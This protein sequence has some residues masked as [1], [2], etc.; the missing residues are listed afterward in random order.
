MLRLICL[1]WGI[2][3][4][5]GT[6][7]QQAVLPI[8]QNFKYPIEGRLAIDVSQGVPGSLWMVYSDRDHNPIYTS[9]KGEIRNGSLAFLEAGYVVDV[10]GEYMHLYTDPEISVRGGL[11]AKAKEIGWVH[12]D[13]VL[14]WTH[15]LMHPNKVARKSM[16]LNQVSSNGASSVT[17]LKAQVL[18]FA[19]NPQRSVVSD[20][21]S[22]LFEIFYV[23]KEE[24]N[25]LLLGQGYS[26]AGTEKVKQTILG[27]VP[28]SR[29]VPWDYRIAT[30]PN[31]YHE[32]A[33]ER[34]KKGKSAQVF[35][36][37]EDAQKYKRNESAAAYWK[38]DTYGNRPSGYWRRFP[39]LGKTDDIW[40]VGLM[41]SVKTSTGLAVNNVK[42]ME[43]ITEL[44]K[45]KRKINIAFVVDG[46]QSMGNYFKATT[47]AIQN[48]VNEL[49]VMYGKQNQNTLRYG[50]VV[51]RDYA[52]KDRK[53][54]LRSLTSNPNQIISFLN[55]IE[56]KD[57]FD[58]DKPEALYYGL[59]N[60]LEH[61]GFKE[62]E[63]NFI[64]LIGDVGT[65]N[66]LDPTQVS[67]KTLQDLLVKYS[68][69]VIAFQAN[70]ASHPT[71]EDFLN[72]TKRLILAT[73]KKKYADSKGV[74]NL[75][76]LQSPLPS[77]QSFGNSYY[78]NQGAIYGKILYPNKG[79]SLSPSK[80]S[81][82]V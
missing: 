59:K 26:C 41:G 11:S 54:E 67:E 34:K 82:E 64:I 50:A 61:I 48:A 77:W 57:Y 33:E 16:I 3:I 40:K 45:R 18:R 30:E 46:T 12:K 13:K 4:F 17:E 21:E 27:W 74:M 29:V 15:C 72:Q 14:M 7:A 42:L 35:R 24:G 68:C 71:Y 20:R 32:G 58:R 65:H 25:S 47:Q 53:I 62:N 6:F 28:K 37:K 43:K 69:N 31:W 78:L 70:R 22:R 76:K 81:K 1:L 75:T 9:S 63:A 52:E 66:R 2:C 60:T 36:T 38:A 10:K 8:P 49:S 56:A 80:L 79:M 23:Y 73:A 51:F 19:T 5:Y 55:A 39:I 44:E